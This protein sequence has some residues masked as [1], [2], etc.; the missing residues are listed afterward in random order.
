MKAK[1]TR[2]EQGAS[3]A[4]DDALLEKLGIDCNSE[5]ELVIR[6]GALLVIPEAERD[7]ILRES[8][9]KIDEQYSEVFRRLAD[10]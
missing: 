3:L 9:E 4:L 2:T 6:D 1:L 5:V 10:S 8:M 7:R